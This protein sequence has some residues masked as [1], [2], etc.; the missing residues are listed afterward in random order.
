MVFSYYLLKYPYSLGWKLCQWLKKD[1]YFAAYCGD[2]LDYHIME[3]VL[4]YLPELRIISKNRQVQS[5]LT[6]LGVK[7]VRLPAFPQ[8]VLMCRLA[9]H[10]FPAA[11]MPKIG[12]RHGPFHFKALSGKESYLLFDHFLFTSEPEVKLAAKA[13]ITNGLGIGY[14]KLDKAFDGSIS[15]TT[16]NDLHQELGLSDKKRTLLFTATWEGSGMSAVQKWYDRL[17]ELT[18]AYNV[19]VSLHPWI[20]E[21][22]REK[23]RNT[24]G[25]HFIESYDTTSYIMLSDICLGDTSSILGECL[26]LDKPLITFK[27]NNSGRMVDYVVEML[28]QISIRID[29][30]EE[31]SEAII[32]CNESLITKSQE[33]QAAK[34]MM[35]SKLDGTAGKQAADFVRR[36]WE[37]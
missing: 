32:A 37:I 2:V 25:V 13:G 31:I 36:V 30:F 33:R 12:M 1:K 27:V 11:G 9:G 26:A 20:S 24:P 3:P 15:K 19:L 16:L 6:K 8:G 14:P 28:E 4:K 34:D 23:V 18:G 29:S 7:S 10:K 21:R 22:Y 5:E 17:S 35:F